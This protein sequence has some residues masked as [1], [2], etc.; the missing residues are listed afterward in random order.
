MA[1]DVKKHWAAEAGGQDRKTLREWLDQPETS[2]R[3]RAGRQAVFERDLGAIW[4]TVVEAAHAGIDAYNA[5]IGY[6]AL[7]LEPFGPDQFRLVRKSPKRE[8][9]I[10]LD[11]GN[12]VLR[13]T[14]TNR[15]GNPDN[16]TWHLRVQDDQLVI[17]WGT[18]KID[19]DE[20]IRSIFHV[21]RELEEKE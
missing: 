11:R 9:Q 20:V 3:G 12:R 1:D 14:A 19:A 17:A 15:D 2:S 5:E 4:K 13:G 8:V 21:L 16:R 6:E 10:R 18:T 7:K